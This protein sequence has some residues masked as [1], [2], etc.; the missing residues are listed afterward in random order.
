MSA[1]IFEVEHNGL[2]YE[3]EFDSDHKWTHH[4]K[5]PDGQTSYSLLQGIR[6]LHIN[7]CNCLGNNP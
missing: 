2:F 3:F 4:T 1:S 6:R 5:W 7:V